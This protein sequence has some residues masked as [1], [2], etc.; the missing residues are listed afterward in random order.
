MAQFK[1][2]EMVLLYFSDDP[3]QMGNCTCAQVTFPYKYCNVCSFECAIIVRIEMHSLRLGWKIIG[4]PQMIY[5][6]FLTNFPKKGYHLDHG[7]QDERLSE[8]FPTV[9]LIYWCKFAL[10]LMQFGHW[11]SVGRNKNLLINWLR[12]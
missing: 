5:Y 1:I 7:W 2:K 6:C 11:T 9:L 10:K 12:A 8:N 4:W 3:A